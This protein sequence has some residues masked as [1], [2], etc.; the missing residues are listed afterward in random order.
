MTGVSR[1]AVI[2]AIPVVASACTGTRMVT[3]TAPADREANIQVALLYDADKNGEVTR[4]EMEAGLA[5]EMTV[6]DS[7]G[8]GVLGLSEMQAENQRRF[9][10]NQTGFSPLIDWNRDGKVDKIEF[11]TTIRSMFAEMD[12][13]Q[14]G[15]LSGIELR[16]PRARPPQPPQAG[17]GRGR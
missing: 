12:A 13:D 3:S 7:D 17:R 10:A 16:V 15:V 14:N 4:Q 11:S 1:I 6:A 2:L 9:V 8:D 5:R